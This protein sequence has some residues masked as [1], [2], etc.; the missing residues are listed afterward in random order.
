MLELILFNS[1]QLTL[2][3]NYYCY[4][5]QA[6]YIEKYKQDQRNYHRKET[7]YKNRLQ[8]FISSLFQYIFHKRKILFKSIHARINVN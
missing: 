6:S 1:F 2:D 3:V 5:F 4:K 7:K 8:K